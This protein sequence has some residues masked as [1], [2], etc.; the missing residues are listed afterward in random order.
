M[1][2]SRVADISEVRGSNPALREFFFLEKIEITFCLSSQLN[3]R[4]ESKIKN[5]REKV[6]VSMKIVAAEK[7]GFED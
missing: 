3:T 4:L 7:H 6:V 2:A 1:V 5:S